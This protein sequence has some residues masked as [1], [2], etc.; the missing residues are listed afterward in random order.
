MKQTIG[1]LSIGLCLF[2]TT[3]VSQGVCQST[4]QQ[5]QGTGWQALTTMSPAVAVYGVLEEAT[6]YT[7]IAWVDASS[8][9]IYFSV[10]NGATWTPR[11]VIGASDKSWVAESDASPALAVD[12]STGL[13]WAA[14]KGKSDGLIFYSTWNGTEWSGEASVSGTGWQAGTSA[15]PTLTWNEDGIFLA[16]K[17]GSTNKI[18]YTFLQSGAWVQQ[19]TVQ[20]KNSD[21]S[22]WT[23]GTNVAPSFESG[24]VGDMGLFWEGPSKGRIF[25]TYMGFSDPVW[26]P[27]KYITCPAPGKWTAQ[28]SL[29]PAAALL[30]TIDAVF[31]KS[32]DD[33]GIYY[34]NDSGGCWAQP[35]LVGGSDWTSYTSVAP[36]VASNPSFSSA[37]ILA[38][39][40]ASDNTI[41][42]L[43][44]Q[45]LTGF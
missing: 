8:G 43:D 31:W 38:W 26:G 34:T 41:W 28:T 25:F 36:A 17:G 19:Q 23:A 15:A 30:G 37:A 18:W 40:H 10:Y 5:V 45:T 3:L 13:V 35:A 7:W 39:Q 21:G 22:K 4:P 24:N 9:S 33:N 6:S 11:S 2:L 16:W 12:Y 29:T 14:W 1:Q 42:F 27:Q 32:A 20:G 44:P